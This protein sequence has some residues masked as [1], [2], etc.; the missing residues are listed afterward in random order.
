MIWKWRKGKKK[1]LRESLI[2][3][4]I[5]L[6]ELGERE[7]YKNTICLENHNSCQNLYVT[8]LNKRDCRTNLLAGWICTVFVLQCHLMF[9]WR[10]YRNP[11]TIKT[12]LISNII[13]LAHV[14]LNWTW[15][16]QLFFLEFILQ[17]KRLIL[18]RHRTQLVSRKT[19]MDS[20]NQ[21]P[22]IQTV[23]SGGKKTCQLHSRLVK[24]GEKK[25]S[26]S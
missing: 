4:G 18:T 9:L 2:Y 17:Y 6:N 21:V 11:L 16:G 22:I 23:V 15:V 7:S 10:H 24:G 3:R 8:S 14:F 26:K 19:R 12:A 1:L 20:R 25:G 13:V 5:L